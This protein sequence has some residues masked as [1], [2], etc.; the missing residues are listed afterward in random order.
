MRL[1]WVFLGI[2]LFVPLD[3]SAQDVETSERAYY[4]LTRL[5][6]G[7]AAGDVQRVTQ[8]GV[9]N[10]IDQQLH[11]ET[12][13][14][15]PSLQKQMDG[16]TTLFAS[17]VD[18]FLRDRQLAAQ[19]KDSDDKKAIEQ[20]LN[21]PVR[22]A[23]DARLLKAIESP[24]QLQEVLV[25]FWFNHFN[26]YAHKDIDR[27]FVG[28]YEQ[29]AIRPYVFGHFH[30]M[31]MATARHPA[32][33]YYLDQ[34]KNVA[35]QA[36]PVAPNKQGKQGEAGINENYAREVMELHTL[37]ANG[38]YTQQD[39]TQLARILSGW[40]FGGNANKKRPQLGGDSKDTVEAEKN[41]VFYFN[42]D[43]H[44]FG[45]KVFLGRKFAG[46]VGEKEGEEALALL[47]YSPVT[48]KHVSY[49]LAQ[50]FVADEPPQSL[51]DHMASVWM[52]TSG[53]LRAVTEAMIKSPEF[54][55]PL[56]RGAK[57]RTPFQYVV[58]A[59]R[60]GGAPMDTEIM[61]GTLQK[62]G[63]E[64][65]G[66]LTPD[67]YKNTID[68]WLNS[69]ATEERLTFAT[70]LGTGKLETM[71]VERYGKKGATDQKNG[72]QSVPLDPQQIEATLD[73]FFSSDTRAAVDSADPKMQA[74]L[75][76]G[77]PEMMRR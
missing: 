58:A 28:Q 71:R 13:P 47:A 63:E 51:V 39:V 64:I 38:G 30:D 65:Y 5:G 48:A 32:M 18:L 12:I 44:D 4:V 69:S 33:L 59:V 45:E 74:A 56:Y 37:G 75:L 21:A 73:N 7:P 53:D 22:E 67:G 50:Y 34:W 62:M 77:S 14:M 46:G 31:L 54:W 2:I 19:R 35:P 41:S 29:Q 52:S 3:A 16:F 27:I 42:P 17:P 55:N 49:E 20:E 57:Y 11:P 66:C 10:Y 6:F 25:D 15:P 9:D 43:L 23:R 26:V 68:A 24:R 36:K 1:I 70:A 76:L 8:M 72:D 40:G 60:A 61:A